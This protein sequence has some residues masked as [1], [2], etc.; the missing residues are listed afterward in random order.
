MTDCIADDKFEAA[1]RLGW[2]SG[3]G[4]WYQAGVACSKERGLISFIN[5]STEIAISIQIGFDEDLAFPSIPINRRSF[6]PVRNG[7]WQY[8]IS[9]AIYIFISG[10][11]SNNNY[12]EMDTPRCLSIILSSHYNS[13]QGLIGRSK[14]IDRQGNALRRADQSKS[15]KQTDKEPELWE[16]FAV[17]KIRKQSECSVAFDRRRNSSREE[18]GGR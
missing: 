5:Y 7:K 10:I 15:H 11:S 16:A 14:S 9:I 18:E 12:S 13:D 3:V 2:A 17:S 8:R 6:F 4:W 1:P